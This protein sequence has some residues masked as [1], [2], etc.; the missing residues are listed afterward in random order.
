VLAEF[1]RQQKPT[2][3]LEIEKSEVLDRDHIDDDDLIRLMNLARASREPTERLTIR[4]SARAESER[5]NLA[6]IGASFSWQLMRHLKASR[7]FSGIDVYFYYSGFKWREADDVSGQVRS[8]ALP[9]DFESEIFGAD[10]LLLE[11]NEASALYPEHHLSAFVK[12]ALAHLRR[13][14]ATPPH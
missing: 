9:L 3:L 5:L 10:C 12:D 1:Q 11:I 13:G 8:P 7:Q 4:P 6:V 2:E 14:S